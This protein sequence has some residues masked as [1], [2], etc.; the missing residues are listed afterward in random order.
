MEFEG[1]KVYL[2]RMERKQARWPSPIAVTSES[3]SALSTDIQHTVEDIN[4]MMSGWDVIMHD[5]QIDLTIATN[6][7]NN[8]MG[9]YRQIA[10]YATAHLPDIFSAELESINTVEDLLASTRPA[11]K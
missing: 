9:L 10:Q 7:L 11:A 1:N 5:E 3:L 2:D 6:I 4:E 8:R